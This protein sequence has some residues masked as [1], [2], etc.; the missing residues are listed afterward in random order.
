MKKSNTFARWQEASQVGREQV[1]DEFLKYLRKTRVR[2]PH[3][4]ALADLVA[5]H[6]ASVQG[7]PCAT[8]TLMRNLRYKTKILSH[9]AKQ[10][11]GAGMTPTP[12]AVSAD[13]TARASVARA[14]LAEGNARRE[15]QRLQVYTS[16]LEQELDKVRRASPEIANSARVESPVGVSDAEFKFVRTCQV[17]RAL[18]SHFELVVE[19]DMH[20]RKI[21]DKSRRRNNVIVDSD[22]ANP[23]FEWLDVAQRQLSSGN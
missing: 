12:N 22:L 1:I 3:P 23:F 4:T 16:N 18:V 21:L 13:P 9:H 10:E 8:S 2:T 6:V 20:A 7:K 15:L 17:V 5:R 19:V 14:E 11:S